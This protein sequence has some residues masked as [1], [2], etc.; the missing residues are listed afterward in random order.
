MAILLLYSS[1][2][3]FYY[4]TLKLIACLVI[5]VTLC[6]FCWAGIQLGPSLITRT[7]SAP[8]PKPGSFKAFT[9]DTLPFSSTLNDTTVV[10]IPAG[11]W[12]ITGAPLLRLFIKYFCQPSV[13]P[14]NVGATRSVSY[15]NFLYDGL[16]VSAS[17]KFA[18]D[19]SI[20]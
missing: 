7:A 12:L 17:F 18:A 3:Q 1:F 2:L 16:V 9:S 19:K 10:Y 5:A 15:S 14:G 13:P 4:S 6:P 8:V 20:D 11:A